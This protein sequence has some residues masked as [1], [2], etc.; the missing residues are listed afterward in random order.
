MR[1]RKA[2]LK[3]AKSIQTIIDKFAKK[4]RM[5][6]RSLSEIYENIRD[7]FIC[8]DKGK[9]IGIS[10]L[11]ILWENLAEIRSVAVLQEY[12]NK[13]VGKKLVEQCL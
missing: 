1:I 12:Q 8:Q 7:F 11:H 6:P 2:T 13:G 4:D 3:D 5:L 9:I 10:A